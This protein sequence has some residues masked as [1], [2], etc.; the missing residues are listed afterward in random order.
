MVHAYIVVNV[1]NAVNVRE[2]TAQILKNVRNLIL[3]DNFNVVVIVCQ[4]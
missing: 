2:S 1:F 4:E 3:Y